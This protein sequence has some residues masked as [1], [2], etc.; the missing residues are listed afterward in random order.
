MYF[1]RTLAVCYDLRSGPITTDTI[2][3][4]FSI[5][6]VALIFDRSGQDVQHT[7]PIDR[8][9]QL[10]QLHIIQNDVS[11][12]KNLQ[13]KQVGSQGAFTNNSFFAPDRKVIECFVSYGRSNNRPAIQWP[14]C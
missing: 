3:L 8:R 14:F 9:L 4:T 2:D 12:S 7:L 11:L 6:G 5:G 13:L 10:S 1:E